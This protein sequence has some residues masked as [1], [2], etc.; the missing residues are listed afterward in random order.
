MTPSSTTQLT[1]ATVVPR[2]EVHEQLPA[3]FEQRR[4]VALPLRSDER[5]AASNSTIGSERR[6]A[7]ATPHGC[8]LSPAPS[9]L[10]LGLPG[11]PVDDLG[12]WL[13]GAFCC[14]RYFSLRLRSTHD[15]AMLI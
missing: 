7:L 9:R 3:S 5:L 1:V 12:Q 14:H 15:L 4:R 2:V 6:A 13:G 10:D 11:G 8:A